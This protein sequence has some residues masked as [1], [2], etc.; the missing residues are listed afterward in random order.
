MLRQITAQVEAD[1]TPH[2]GGLSYASPSAA[3]AASATAINEGLVTGGLLGVLGGGSI[4]VVGP[5]FANLPM[6]S[7]WRSKWV[8]LCMN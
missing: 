8:S 1:I 5:G 2:L 7:L 4:V 3:A 6:A